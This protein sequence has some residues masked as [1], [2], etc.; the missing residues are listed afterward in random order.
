VIRL[1][2]HNT[3]TWEKP[4]IPPPSRMLRPGCRTSP[5]WNGRFGRRIEK[6]IHYAFDLIF[7]DG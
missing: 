1:H 7:L 6:L 5:L 2:G 3:E 4:N